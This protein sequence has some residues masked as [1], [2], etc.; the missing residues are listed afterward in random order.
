MLN[1]KSALAACVV[2]LPFAVSTAEAADPV[3]EIDRPIVF[4][5]LDWD[6]NAFHNSVAQFIAEKGYGCET[7]VIPGSTIPLLN[8]MARG[9]ID[10]TMEIWPD[11][12]TEALAEGKAKNQFVDLGVNFPDATQAW[13]IPKYLVE[14]DDAPAKGLKSVS[15]LPKY[16]DVF[17]DPEE[18][19]KGRFYNCIA[20]WGCEVINSKKLNA[21]GLLDSFVNFRPGTGAALSA[22]IESNIRRKK[23][24]VFYYWGP[25]WVMGKVAD[26]LIQLEEP[27]Y[28][29]EAWDKLSEETDPSKVTEA[30]A[31]PLSA[32][33]VYVNT[34]FHTTAPKL[35]EF[36]TAYETTSNDVSKALAYMQDTGGTTDD[37]AAEFLKNNEEIWTGWVPADVAERVKSAL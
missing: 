28:N 24:I 32:T 18:P 7:D 29:K 35:V 21:Y 10:V 34:E 19:E 22:A 36:L 15:D 12:V 13:F 2:A 5:G 30:V 8:G 20:G 1:F 33:H 3:C 4:A 27:A 16:K 23:P 11:N 17:S 37:A 9:D 14:G 31:Y 25:T 6:S 26:D